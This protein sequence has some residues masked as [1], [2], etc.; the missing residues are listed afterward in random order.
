LKIQRYTIILTALT[1]LYFVAG[2]LGLTLAFVNPSATAV[3][4]CSGIALAALLILGYRVWP[5]ILLGAFFV[6][7]TTAG[8][9]MT[10]MGIAT[11]NTL[12][13]IVGAWLVNRWAGG[14]NAMYQ[15]RDVFAFTILAS[16]LSTTIA[17]TIGTASL[18]IG[19]LVDPNTFGRVWLTWWLG[20]AVGIAVVAPLLLFW[21]RRPVRSFRVVE[22][23]EFMATLVVLAVA[24]GMIFLLPSSEKHSLEY[25]VIPILMWAAFRFGQREAATALVLLSAAAIGGTLQSRGPFSA[26]S[27]HESLLLLQSF[28]G[29]IGITTL[30]LAAEVA[31]RRR[32][33]SDARTLAVSDPLTGLGNYRKLLDALEAEIQRSERTGRPFTFLLLDVDDLKKINDVHGHVVGSRALCRFASVLRLNSR[34]IDTVARYGGDE[35]AIVLPE[36]DRPAAAEVCRRITEGLASEHEQPALKASMGIA[37]WPHDGGTI[38]ALLRSAD[39][40]LYEMKNGRSPV[41]HLPDGK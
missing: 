18:N 13:G 20:D 40:A 7:L 26:D 30:V 39:Q 35:F 31:E 1:T 29:V 32:A 36:S 14:R 21:V 34:T 23:L 5:A 2:K 8:T 12:E 25:L 28:L 27:P 11:G 6:N 22:L 4:P 24:A 16:I 10:S 15:T 9:L 41:V 3:W 33:E 38:E 37:S 17:A 19:G